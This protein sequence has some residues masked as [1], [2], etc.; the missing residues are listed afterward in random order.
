VLIYSATWEEHLQHIEA[1]FQALQQHQLFVKLSKCSF[2]KELSLFRP[3]D[4]LCW[5]INNPKK[6]QIV[7]DWSSPQN[8]KELRSFL[9]MARYYRKYVKNFGLLSKPLTNL[10]KKGVIYV[11][12]AETKASF[13]TLKTSLMAALVLALPNFSKS[14]ELETDASDKGIGAVLQQ[15]GH[16]IAYVS[17]ALGPKAQGLSTYEKECLAILLVV[18][19]WRPYL[20]H[21]EF[22]IKTD[23]KS[24]IHLDDQRLTTPWQH[25]ALSKLL[26]LSYKIVY[27]QGRE[28]R[29]SD[30]L[31]R[32]S[33]ASSHELSAVSVATSPWVLAL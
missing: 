19:Y 27:K 33:H 10:L 28:N 29:V 20:Q 4:Q 18:D 11:W 30:V 24:L 5:S 15:D 2:A 21:S 26:G 32:T 9:G 1:V 7:E 12:N 13:Q 8:V 17:K 6:I 23:Q 16:P 3:C 25:K 31:S 14:F 22:T